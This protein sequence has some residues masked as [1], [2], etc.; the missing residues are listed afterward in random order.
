MLPPQAQKGGEE[1]V[2]TRELGEN[3]PNMHGSPW[4]SLLELEEPDRK[5]PPCLLSCPP[6]PPLGWTQTEGRTQGSL[7]MS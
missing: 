5:D 2:T 1:V 7:P 4:R 6:V 3:V